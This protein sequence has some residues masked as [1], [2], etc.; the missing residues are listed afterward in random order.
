MKDLQDKPFVIL[1]INSDSDKEELK[2]ALAREN[3]TWR[4]WWDGGSTKGPIASRWNIWGWPTMY[5]LDAKG[6]IRYKGATLGG[7]TVVQG[8]D[9]KF[10][11]QR[12]LDR[13][14]TDLLKETERGRE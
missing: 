11:Q 13:A 12:I 2:K 1:G 9:G 10:Q 7:I 6:K 8:K 5:L 3:I 14:I 4:S